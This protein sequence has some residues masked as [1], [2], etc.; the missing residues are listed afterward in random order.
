LTNRG[1]FDDNAFEILSWPAQS[2]DL[3]RIENVWGVIKEKIFAQAER[4]NSI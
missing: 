2:P 3:S 4:I 1:Y